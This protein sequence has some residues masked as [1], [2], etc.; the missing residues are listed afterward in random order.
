MPRISQSPAR[1]HSRDTPQSR[2]P[3]QNRRTDTTLQGLDGTVRLGCTSEP[4]RP[5]L[6]RQASDHKHRP[7]PT[8]HVTHT[9]RTRIT[10]PPRAPTVSFRTL[11]SIHFWLKSSQPCARANGWS[12][13]SRRTQHTAR[14]S[15]ELRRPSAG[16]YLIANL[17]QRRV[18]C[19]HH[20]QHLLVTTV[21]TIS[22][23]I[24]HQGTHITPTSDAARLLRHV[25]GLSLPH[26]T[27]P[28]PCNRSLPSRR[29]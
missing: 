3:P 9:H 4:L 1:R 29:P 11:Q 23:T 27:Y 13:S 8:H 24:G 22:P 10:A 18:Y 25:N 6:P 28:A 7:H 26:T 16:R 21:T 2:T 19:R 15:G 17:H 12:S 20:A 5:P 14:H